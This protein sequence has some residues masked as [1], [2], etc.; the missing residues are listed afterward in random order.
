M[1]GSPLGPPPSSPAS[2]L[3]NEVVGWAQV[4]VPYRHQQGLLGQLLP[5][6]CV[7]ELLPGGDRKEGAA[8]VLPSF[9]NRLRLV[10]D[11]GQLGP[12]FL[13]EAACWPPPPQSSRTAWPGPGLPHGIRGSGSSSEHW[14]Y[15]LF[16]SPHLDAGI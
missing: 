8:W 3:T 5:E 15:I 14:S 12:V 7:E 1:C 6:A 13:T 4:I 16:F 2:P 11:S 9:R 10:R